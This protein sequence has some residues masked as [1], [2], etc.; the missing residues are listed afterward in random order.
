MLKPHSRNAKIYS[1]NLIRKSKATFIRTSLEL[2]KND[3][4][5]LWH[6]INTLI[7]AGKDQNGSIKTIQMD[8]GTV[9]SDMAAAEL[10][11]SYYVDIGI[12]LAKA[13]QSREWMPPTYFPIQ[14]NVF[15]FRL[16]TE[17]ECYTL[18]KGI[19]ITKSS[20][21]PDINST[22]IKDAFEGLN[23]EITYLLN[24]SLMTG[25]F[26]IS[27]GLSIVTPIPKDGNKL[28]PGNWRPISQMPI[29]GRL[30]EKAIHIQLSYHLD[31]WGILHPNQHGFRRGKSTG[32]AFFQNLKHL[33]DSYDQNKTTA[34]TYIDYKKAFDTVIHNILL[35]KLKLYGLDSNSLTWFRNYLANRSQCTIVN[36]HKS[37]VKTI[38]C[39]VPQGSTLGPTLFILYVNDLFYCDGIDI[40]NTLMY[41]DDTVIFTSSDTLEFVLK[42][43]NEKISKIVDWCNLNKLTIN[44][45][46]TKYTV[47]NNNNASSNTTTEIKCKGH[48]L[49]KVDSYRYL[50]VDIASD[51]N[52]NEYVNNA[53]KRANNKVYMFSKM[54]KYITTYASIMI[55]K[56]TILPFMD[57]SGFLM[58]SACHYS[59]SKLDKIQ[60]RCLRLIEY[61]DKAHREKDQH[62]LMKNYRIDPIRDRRK[63]QLL[64]FI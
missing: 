25:E 20:A 13:F 43:Q 58:D 4:K 48:T 22:Y 11:N 19:D 39:G 57:Y 15:S 31:T 2:N 44:E 14:S 47:F 27:W 60:K 64:H 30:L 46:K 35:E 24:E 18:I 53:Y 62:I 23:F 34:A 63:R 52:M 7:G 49:E 10:M 50:G 3:P 33:Y 12:K 26:P 55:Y 8:D 37:S 51:L 29:I 38:N 9:L 59:L 36:G 28:L 5:K 6:E 45:T 16:I 42:D 32:S 41:A 21:V 1:Q 17:K 40:E 61:K 56:Q 54:R